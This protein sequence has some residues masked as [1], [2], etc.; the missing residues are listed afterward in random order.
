MSIFE[1][2]QSGPSEP[3]GIEA[4]Q[5]DTS[6]WTLE[7]SSERQKCWITDSQDAVVLDYFPFPTDLPCNTNDIQDIRRHFRDMVDAQGGAILSVDL[8][9]LQG[10]E[11]SRNVFKFRF[12]QPGSMSMIY[13]GSLMIP[14]KNF[15]YVFRTES[16]ERGDPGTREAAVA[17]LEKPKKNKITSKLEISTPDMLFHRFASS[18]IEALP[19]DNEKYDEAFP[20]H[21]LSK[22]RRF[23]THIGETLSISPTIRQD[24]LF[25]S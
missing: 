15:S 5:C 22:V 4:I 2:L 14:F 19:S 10:I 6:E 16:F 17:I 8:Q 23:L 25:P 21:P 12:P 18:Q 3:P 24:L 11:I 9:T 7:E 13:L 1:Q 20:N